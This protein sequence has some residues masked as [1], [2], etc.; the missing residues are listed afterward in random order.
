MGVMK[1]E[2]PCPD[3]KLVDSE[4]AD[5]L[6]QTLVAE[7][8]VTPYGRD[9][10]G[11]CHLYSIFLAEQA[12]K[13][14]FYSKDVLMGMFRRHLRRIVQ[15]GQTGLFVGSRSNN[16]NL[17]SDELTNI[18]GGMTYVVDIANEERF[19]RK[20][21]SEVIYGMISLRGRWWPERGRGDVGELQG[22]PFPPGYHSH[23]RAL[24]CGLPLE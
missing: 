23:G 6:S 21:S 13:N 15:A 14:G 5:L 1:V 20:F 22:S 2:L 12:I 16:E 9:N 3:Q 18:R 8:N 11:H 4:L 17:L 19:C 7:R 10:L 24:V